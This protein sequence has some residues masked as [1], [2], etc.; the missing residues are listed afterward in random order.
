MADSIAGLFLGNEMNAFQRL[1]AAQKDYEEKW[2]DSNVAK[3]EVQKSLIDFYVD[4][5]RVTVR[6]DADC[7][8]SF[9]NGPTVSITT[10]SLAAILG[11]LIDAG[12]LTIETV[13]QVVPAK[14]G[15][16]KS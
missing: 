5:I 2:D 16:A 13:S 8:I 3:V 14:V 15:E 1:I 7:L 9:P 10:Q 6:P 11:K 12:A 4:H